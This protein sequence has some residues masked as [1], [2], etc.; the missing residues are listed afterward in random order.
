MN[1]NERPRSHRL[2]GY[3]YSQEGAYHLTICA[4]NRQH[5]FGGLHGEVVDLSRIGLIV[6]EEWFRSEVIRS[7]LILDEFMIMPNH[8]HGIVFISF[9]NELRK[10]VV[11]QAHSRAQLQRQRRSVSSFV[12][13]FK[14]VV[15]TRIRKEI[16]QNIRQVWQPN[17]HD[18]I[19]R[20]EDELLKTRQYIRDNPLKWSLDEYFSE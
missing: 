19:I 13:Q 4:H 3:D 9:G 18:R 8:F 5:L 12:A 6:K 17:F 2:K 11:Q 15:T 10:P 16:S 20:D 14:S 1:D 7:E